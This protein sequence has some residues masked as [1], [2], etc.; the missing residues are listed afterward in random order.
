MFMENVIMHGCDKELA[1]SIEPGN[2]IEDRKRKYINAA[3]FIL[4]GGAQGSIESSSAISENL[5]ITS[6]DIGIY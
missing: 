6:P 5:F 4:L 3:K 2:S 1:L